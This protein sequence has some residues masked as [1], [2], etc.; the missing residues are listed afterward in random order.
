MNTRRPT[1][2]NSFR[3]PSSKK[4]RRKSDELR[5]PQ[6]RLRKFFLEA[7]E[8]RAMMSF[9]TSAGAILYTAFPGEPNDVTI[10]PGALTH[11]NDN[12]NISLLS[13]CPSA[14]FLRGL[15]LG[16]EV[17]FIASG[18]FSW[19]L[20]P[21][22]LPDSG[23]ICPTIAGF[24][25]MF[26]GALQ[27]S[28]EQG[29]ASVV[30][31]ATVP[32]NGDLFYKV[33]ADG[34]EPITNY[35]LYNIIA[36]G[37]QTHAETVS[38]LDSDSAVFRA[39]S[40]SNGRVITGTVSGTDRDRFSF[41]A[42]TGKQYVVMLD[43]DPE[44]DGSVTATRLKAFTVAGLI[45]NT[46]LAQNISASGGNAI[47]PF[48]VSSNQKIV[49]DVENTGVG[50]GNS[51]RFV[52][53]EF[54]P[55]ST[56]SQLEGPQSISAS[57]PGLPRAISDNST[58]TSTFNV[59]GF[60]GAITDIDVTLNIS[61]TYDND[62]TVTLI[63][64]AG[65]RVELFS[66]VGGEFNNFTNTT[67]DDG[68]SFNPIT[69]GSAPFSSTFSPEGLLSTLNGENANGNWSLEVKDNFTN[70]VG[71]LNNWSLKITTNGNTDSTTNAT[72]VSAGQYGRGA[73]DPAQDIDFWKRSSVTTGALAFSYVDTSGSSGNKDSRLELIAN[74]GTTSLEQ[75]DDGGP[76]GLT[77]QAITELKRVFEKSG[78][79]SP[80]ADP[81]SVIV[82]LGD[83][84]DRVDVRGISLPT[85]LFG[86][87][88]QDLLLGGLGP[89]V[90][91]GGENADTLVGSAGNDTMD[92]G[93]G[94]DQ[95]TVDTEYSSDDRVIGGDGYDTIFVP[96]SAQKN[97]I[98]IALNRDAPFE[99]IIDVSGAVTRYDI[100]NNDI[101]EI[102]VDGGNG[103]D[104]LYF[105]DV[106]VTDNETVVYVRGPA[107]GSGAIYVVD[108]SGNT[109]E[110]PI[111]FDGIERID[112]LDG[113]LTRADGSSR[114]I[115]ISDP[116]FEVGANDTFDLSTLLGAGSSVNVER[117][118]FPAGDV[119]V[120]KVVAQKTGLLD[121]QVL[122]AQN[123]AL[124]GSGD[125]NIQVYDV[126][127]NLIASG[128][129]A[130]NDERIQIPAVQGETYF[131][132]VFGATGPVINE[133]DVTVTNTAAPIPSSMVLDPTN[134]TGR[135]DQDQVTF[136]T[137]GL[138]YLVH[139]DL[140]AFAA[141]GVTVLTAAQA[142]GGVTPG[143]A[144]EVFNEGVSVGFATAVAGTNNQTFEITLNA[145]LLK[146]PVGGP[147]AAGGLGYEGFLNFLTAA[148]KVFDPRR[149]AAVAAQP[150]IG[151]SLVSG[152][153][154]VT[155]D[156]IAPIAPSTPD[157]LPSSDGGQSNSDN[158]TLVN[159]IAL[160]GT[161]EANSLV[162]I[163]ANGFIVGQGVVGSDATDGVIGNGLGSWEVTTEP[164]APA[165]V[166]YRITAKVE[167]LAGNISPESVAL[168]VLI[169]PSGPQ[170]T[171]VYITGRGPNDVNPFNLFG[172]K[173]GN[174]SQGP[175]PA[176]R[177]LTIRLQDLPNREAAFFANYFALNPTVSA[178]PGNFVLVGDA[179]GNVAISQ[180]VLVN[181]PVVDGQPATASIEL[182]FA[183]PLLDDRYSLVI[184][185]GVVD[186]AG[187]PLDGESNALQPNAGPN[188]PS[189]NT[190]PGGDFVARFTVDSR[191]EIGNYSAGSAFIDA[192]GN[193]VIDPQGLAADYSN[194]DLVFQIGTI[195]DSLFA[196]KFEP[197]GAANN[198]D[199]YDKLGA[200]GYDNV[201]KKYRFL[202]DFNYDGVTDLSVVSAFQVNA[203]PVAGNFAT[204]RNGD[205]IGLFD[206]TA[207][208]I[209]DVGDNQLHRKIVSNMRGQPFVGDFNGDGKDDFATFDAKTNIFYFD[210]NRDGQTD[211]TL[212]VT[213]PLN[214]VTEIPV[215]GDLNLDGIDDLG[216]RVTN[217]QGSPTPNIA[218]WY[219]WISD[220]TGQALPH[221]LFQPF[222]PDPLGN[223]L[224]AAFGD[225]F[226]LP[227]IG[228]FDPPVSASV[229]T[230]S[231]TNKLNNLDVNNDGIISAFDAL[232]IISHLNTGATASATGAAP[233]LDVNADSRITAFD[234]INV[235][236]YLNLHPVGSGGEDVSASAGEAIGDSEGSDWLTLLALDSLEADSR[237]SG[238][239]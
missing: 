136:E 191:P 208:Y 210:T 107:A 130:D 117:A 165:S 233:Y 49:L 3:R 122:F 184:K 94:D 167:D 27:T 216:L 103:V 133:Y 87:T 110:P 234:A 149:D 113:V 221:N 193:W 159:A 47:G 65:T 77:D 52:V 206:G 158:V 177:S 225:Y 39:A 230:A 163:F 22:D 92:G 31:G 79:T 97:V 180:I 187:N 151:R 143:V 21:F 30:A 209:D 238:K 35:N 53:A 76:P 207:W 78:L 112:F 16:A 120:Y 106:G 43:Q 131:L 17:G 175:T 68:F 223:D 219:F 32:Q 135:S 218:E 183:S 19:P 115:V 85:Q 98:K 64:P 194:R 134:D 9:V 199:G 217:R 72:V 6:L 50:A 67:L 81:T 90:M 88:G 202:L 18:S 83:R 69:S 14:E 215:A 42:V 139:A 142:S 214:T 82:N 157:L 59:S 176:V 28:A 160:Q 197:V 33:T 169:D 70:D 189:G 166:S 102:G 153:L 96:S 205:E 116:S 51:Y 132:R 211:D 26:T 60:T 146:Y 137:T 192:N 178:A 100:P 172:L 54:D 213:G 119:D 140:A 93:S 37:G 95:F 227:I 89:D 84:D 198:N 57:D 58:V 236:N 80:T 185:D 220:V 138:R 173:P 29:S 168:R 239:Q 15:A 10:T 66:N 1:Q 237:R 63:S 228:N 44:R 71:N 156:N 148:V 24:A 121:F 38:D 12:P 108:A 170:V 154:T 25:S 91:D 128:T 86:G 201:A 155:V 196:G 111:T 141:A 2:G 164:L 105:R 13:T 74:D 7:L 150:A 124:P 226:S 224:F 62:L 229:G 171:D 200:Y 118:I 46:P 222:A 147:N 73:V 34:G 203:K 144:V 161:A 23:V 127:G 5:G 145:N 55:S 99:A 179:T 36:D 174:A 123:A 48:A 20:I 129:S 235:I 181:D 45:S 75:A 188:F 104:E 109:T 125:I 56:A 195:S 190:L 182:R 231:L 232:Q 162:T 212:T 11:V 4:P 101:E 40:P 61:H 152:P 204:T 114:L 8:D 186:P 126:N 41:N